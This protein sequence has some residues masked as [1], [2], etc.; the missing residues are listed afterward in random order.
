LIIFFAAKDGEAHN[1]NITS[2]LLSCLKEEMRGGEVLGVSD[3]RHLWVRWELR[4]EVR[5][6]G[7]RRL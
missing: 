3:R 6:R 7:W 2:F 1:P 5:E 4:V